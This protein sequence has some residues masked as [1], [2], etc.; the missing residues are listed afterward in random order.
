MWSE[1]AG[2]HRSNQKSTDVIWLSSIADSRRS[3]CDD[4]MFIL[5]DSV[6]EAVENDD[7]LAQV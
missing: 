4:G 5:E 7:L 1:L 2:S 3:S 6:A